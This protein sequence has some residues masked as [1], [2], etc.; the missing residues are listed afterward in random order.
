M[1]ELSV[2]EKANAYDEA[3]KVGKNYYKQGNEDT[4]RMMSTC[5]PVLG[6]SKDEVIREDLLDYFKNF[7]DILWSGNYVKDIIAWLEKQ[8]EKDMRKTTIWKHWKDGIAGNGEGKQIYLIK[9]GNSYSLSSCLGQE[10]DYIELSDLDK[11]MLPEK[12]CEQKSFDYENANI[13]QKDFAPKIEPK[14]KKGDWVILTAGELSTTLQIVNVDINKKR[15]WFNDNSYLPIVD[16]EC[17]HHWTI[18]D[19]K[20]GDVLVTIDTVHP[21]IYKGCLDSNH[22]DSP[23]AYCGI[24]TEGDFYTSGCYWWTDEKIQPSTKEQRGILFQKMKEAGYEW[25]AEKKELNKIEQKPSVT[26]WSEDDEQ[27][28]LVCKNALRKY[29]VTDKWDSNIISQWLDNKIKSLRPQE[30]WKPNKEQLEAL[31]HSLGDYKVRIFDDRYERL[32][33]LYNNL[34]KLS[35]E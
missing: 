6:K 23:V 4:K 5:F 19:A 8:V 33:S 30:Q 14:F 27:Y 31:E 16:E 28:L 7:P 11:L 9:S 20:D 21:F 32:K 2:E 25:D 22:P 1:K 29:E 10:C 13:K 12:Q 17:L 3:L 34:K 15:Y 35:E 26:E 18:Q 24:D